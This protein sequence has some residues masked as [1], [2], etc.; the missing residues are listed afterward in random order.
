MCFC[1]YIFF[2]GMHTCDAKYDYDL[3][4]NWEIKNLLENTMFILNAFFLL[5]NHVAQDYVRKHMAS[6][7]YGAFSSVEILRCCLSVLQNN[8]LTLVD[9]SDFIKLAYMIL[10]K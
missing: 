6:V 7:H 3:N 2:L 4:V 9:S 8:T 5:L 10:K 1:L